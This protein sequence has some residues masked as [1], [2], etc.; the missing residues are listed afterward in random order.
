[1]VNLR[2]PEYCYKGHKPH[3]QGMTHISPLDNLLTYFGEEGY[4][5]VYR[6]SDDVASLP[7][8][9]NLPPSTK[10]MAD[11]LIF[12][13]DAEDV[14][15]AYK[16]MQT[17]CDA[18][19][20]ENIEFSV[21][22]SG[23]K[24]FHILVPT[25]QFNFQPTSDD[26]VLLRMAESIAKELNLSTWDR[27]VY[28]KTRVF[29][30]PYSKHPKTGRYK[31][32][33]EV[34]KAN[35][36]DIVQFSEQ[37]PKRDLATVSVS[38]PNP[39]PVLE[40][41][42][43]SAKAP[44]VREVQE[45]I[46]TAAGGILGEVATKGN[47]NDL[48]YKKARYLAR[49]AI[50][51]ADA[52]I[53]LENWNKVQP[54]PLPPFEVSK[55]VTSAF[56]KG[57]NV[58]QDT[59]DVKAHVYDIHSAIEA[60]K[61]A[62]LQ[63]DGGIKT[64]WADLDRY[65]MGFQPQDVLIWV[66]RT[67]TFKTA[68]A[69]SVSQRVSFAQKKH[70]LCFSMEMPVASLNYRHMQ[71]AEKMS[72]REVYDAIRNG[73][74]FDQTRELF[75]YTHVVGLSNLN[76]E[77]V[78][79]LLDHYL[80]KY[81]DLSMVTFDYLSLFEGCAN[82]PKATARQITELKTVVSK[83]LPCPM[84]VLVQAKRT[85][86]GDGGDCEMDLDGAKDSGYIEDTGDFIFGAW[87]YTQNTPDGP[88]KVVYAKPLKARA[89]DSDSYPNTPYFALAINQEQVRVEDFIYDPNPPRFKRAQKE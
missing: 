83:I 71:Y 23:S 87:N 44:V 61:R 60:S 26:G 53:I 49:R 82:D 51:E 47:R 20:T 24:G 85:Y 41:I 56:A 76:T 22:Y 31:V 65:T 78:C 9:A 18:L 80:E 3:V 89:Y 79:R 66:A 1:M 52:L 27:K 11:D 2:F 73:H 68:L 84:L 35:L 55:T 34:W 70:A 88:Q 54:D 5:S 16:D 40:R 74:E 17:L 37:P 36:V 19:E 12:D 72:R 14:G 63:V 50:T 75:E 30:A 39:S 6:F 15:E 45:H 48:L 29:R 86:E 42:Y 57:V 8:L 4:H 64:G 28:N 25:C 58:L 21:W 10:A 38:S 59:G 46:S 77:K 13:L 81:K 43:A 33:L 62:Y 69:S 67:R 32:P 7:S